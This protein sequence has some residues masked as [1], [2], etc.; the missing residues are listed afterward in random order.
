[1]DSFSA[2]FVSLDVL[3]GFAEARGA[4]GRQGSDLT[5]SQMEPDIRGF[6][7]LWFR[8]SSVTA[9][10]KGLPCKSLIIDGYPEDVL[11]PLPDDDAK[12]TTF[13]PSDGDIIPLFRGDPMERLRPPL[14]TPPMEADRRPPPE[15]SDIGDVIA[16]PDVILAATGDI[17]ELRMLLLLLDELLMGDE[18]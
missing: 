9:A 8:L 16:P 13:I 6:V 2:C 10:P 5:C 7:L 11:W 18:A 14:P 17:I 1:M 12:L 4:G 15:T 3:D